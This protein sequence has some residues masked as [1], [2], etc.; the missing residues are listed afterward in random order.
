[1]SSHIV[2]T[3]F[4]VSIMCSIT[5]LTFPADYSGSTQSLKFKPVGGDINGPFHC[6][7]TRPTAVFPISDVIGIPDGVPEAVTC[8]FLC[9]N[10]VN[11]TGYNY[12]S[13]DVTSVRRPLSGQTGQCEL[14]DYTPRDCATGV[15]KANCASYQVCLATCECYFRLEKPDVSYP[16]QLLCYIAK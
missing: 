9:S 6:A 11:C 4:L 12:K 10:Y 8:G 15:T 7:L 13:N 2:C 5:N 1:M 3:L 16:P 14:F